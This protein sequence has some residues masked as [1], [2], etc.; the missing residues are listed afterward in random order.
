MSDWTEKHETSIIPCLAIGCRRGARWLVACND[1]FLLCKRHH[2]FDHVFLLTM[3]YLRN[4]N[5][6]STI[7]LTV[8]MNL[9]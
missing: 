1:G 5:S 9:V 3:F 8:C 2:D 7:N 6:F 4:I